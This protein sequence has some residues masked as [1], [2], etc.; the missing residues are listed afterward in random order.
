MSLTGAERDGVSEEVQAG[1]TDPATLGVLPAPAPNPVGTEYP[2]SVDELFGEK[3]EY[4]AGEEDDLSLPPGPDENAFTPFLSFVFELWGKPLEPA[5]LKALSKASAPVFDKY[6]PE[7]AG[8]Y[9]H[10]IVFCMV[11]VPVILRRV[12]GGK[13]PLE[14]TSSDP[15]AEG[16]R[17]DAAR[18]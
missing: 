14:P 7:V 11:A 2:A 13:L 15:G 12:I 8:E 16:V 4:Q 18:P 17:Q 1:R 9:S 5:E 6:L 10:E 3:E